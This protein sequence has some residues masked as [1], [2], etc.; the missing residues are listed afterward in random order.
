[1][2]IT[3]SIADI[4]KKAPAVC[5]QVV[6]T[7]GTLAGKAKDSAVVDAAVNRAVL[8]ALDLRGRK[9][10]RA[11]DD[12]SREAEAIND[13]LLFR[14]VHDN[15]STEY[16]R[17]HG[18]TAITSIDEY[19]ER[20]P[21]STYDDYAPYIERMVK[22]GEEGLITNYP[23]THYA[24]TSGSIG[25]PKYIPVCQETVDHYTTY[26]TNLVYG[27]LGE[28]YRNTTGHQ[29]NP[30]H[31]LLAL[32]GKPAFT[33]RGIPMGPI[34][35]T[36]LNKIKG[37]LPYLYTTPAD[38]ITTQQDMNL[39]YIKTRYALA[40]RD[41][42]G[43]NGSF[44]TQ[45]V[46]L[47][48]FVR[49]NWELLCRDIRE[50]TIHDSIKIPDDVREELLSMTEPDP[51]RAAELEREFKLGFET[52]IIPRIWPRFSFVTGIGTAAFAPYTKR[53]R[54][55]TG[56]NVPYE[57]TVYAASEALMA[58]SRHV[59]DTSYVLLPDGAYYEFIPI[60][61]EE[62]NETTIG[63][64][65]LEEGKE[66]E[67]VL[68]TPSGFYR[69]RIYDVIRVTGFYNQA[70]LIQFIYR[71]NQMVSIGG[72]KTNGEMV[73]WA[74]EEFTKRTGV[75]V[76]D[77]S[78][79]ADTSTTPG[80]YTMFVEPERPVPFDRHEECRE[81]L[82][83]LLGQANPS[84]GDKMR[85]RLI[86]PLT[87]YFVQQ[88]TYQLYRDIMVSK[89]RS[90]NQLKPVRVIDTPGKHRFFC[91]FIATEEGD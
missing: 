11:V 25:V 32:D 68:T 38:V 29:Y 51:K 58:A 44:M 7:A 9:S 74:I 70:P 28:Y 15:A 1:M 22:D 52:P 71:K 47:M 3:K 18:F 4:A 49:D 80:H 91:T 13:E 41:L 5:K 57:H 83:R 67:V 17:E 76:S 85:T 65:D 87:L 64:A 6:S 34:S 37:I 20:V 30:G 40:Y 62:G 72:E 27:V 56:K 59:G 35:A 8:T 42:I 33:E 84:L 66:Y 60:D 10:L 75:G 78:V 69:Y 53:M 12:N 81:T 21:L 89:G 24:R 46:D 43:I 90:A 61:A 82:E 86:G 88:E 79:Y 50:G 19:K 14:I 73:Q 77:Y 55:Y 31:V 16:G 2:D 45:V 48:D 26:A 36:A 23:V 63:I 39:K 54:A